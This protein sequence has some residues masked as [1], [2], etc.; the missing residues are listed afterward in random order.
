MLESALVGRDE[1]KESQN[2]QGDQEFHCIPIG[3]DFTDTLSFVT[4]GG[5]GSGAR[6]R[7]KYSISGI[8]KTRLSP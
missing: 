7:K 6:I 4:H 2:Y 8:R 1:E 5:G 3:Q